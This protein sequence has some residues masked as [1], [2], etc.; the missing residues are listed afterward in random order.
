MFFQSLE[1]E[2]QRKNKAWSLDFLF[3]QQRLRQNVIWTTQTGAHGTAQN[4]GQVFW[5]D[6]ESP[7]VNIPKYYAV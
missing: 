5:A 7:L 3:K 1:V 6:L 2:D 4:S